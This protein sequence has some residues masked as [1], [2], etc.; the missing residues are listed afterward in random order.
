MQRVP[1][2]RPRVL[3]LDTEVF[4]YG[5]HAA[6]AHLRFHDGSREAEGGEMTFF[7]NGGF[8]ALPVIG[9]RT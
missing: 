1:I 7:L 4:S 8:S 3:S 5:V 9:L 2:S 6:L